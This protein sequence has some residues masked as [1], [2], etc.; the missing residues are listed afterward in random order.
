MATTDNMAIG[1]RFFMEQDRLRGGPARELCAPDY[2][3]YLAGIPPMDYEGHQ[4]FGRAFYGGFPD[5]Y[6]AIDDLIVEGVAEIRGEFDQMGMLRQLG[7][8]D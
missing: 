6:H 1:P 8:M 5:L 3:I 4:Q 2:I 7:V